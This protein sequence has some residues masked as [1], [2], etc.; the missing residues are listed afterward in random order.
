MMD[1]AF[2]I[3]LNNRTILRSLIEN[4][5]L[6]ELNKIP[7]GFGNNIIWNVAHAVVSQQILVYGLSSLTPMVPNDLI[8]QFRKGTKPERDLTQKEVDDIKNL[9]FSTIEKT[10]E[11]YHNGLFKTFQEYTT[12]TKT[13]LTNVDEAI[14]FN[15][16]HEGI[17]LGY[18]LALKKSL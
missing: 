14:E 13:T 1:W 4:L 9:L 6:K 12:S 10:K 2:E 3:T 11:D 7:D 18:I 17:H 16:Y 8:E 5:S 15:V